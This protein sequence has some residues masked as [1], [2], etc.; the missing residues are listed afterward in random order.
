MPGLA[1]P[2]M[3]ARLADLAHE[4]MP[5]TPSEFGKFMPTKP[6]SGEGH[7]GGQHQAGLMRTPQIP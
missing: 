3:K 5:M 2:K 6:R 1:D 7:P 4:P